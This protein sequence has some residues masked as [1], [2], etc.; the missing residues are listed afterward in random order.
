VGA[1]LFLHSISKDRV[2]LVNDKAE[3]F[4]DTYCSSYRVRIRSQPLGLC[5][6]SQNGTRVTPLTTNPSLGLHSYQTF[7]KKWEWENL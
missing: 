1:T 7:L 2:C 4:G 6:H 3:V 5:R